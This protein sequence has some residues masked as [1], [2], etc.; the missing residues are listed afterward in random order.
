[1]SE[2]PV[3]CDLGQLDGAERARQ[4]T[5]LEALRASVRAV[6]ERPEGY[7]FTFASDAATLARLAEFIALES[8][9]CGFLDF[10]L[11]VK[12]GSD[13]AVLSLTGGAGAKEFIEAEM[14]GAGGRRA[15]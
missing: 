5:T 11:E 3:V 12:A 2:L 13:I 8:R 7:A 4:Q 1:M 9:C 6:E 15:S 10:R 14:I